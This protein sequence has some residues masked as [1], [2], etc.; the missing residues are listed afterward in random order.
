[1]KWTICQEDLPVLVRD[2]LV[3]GN[4]QANPR[5]ADKTEIETIYH[6]LI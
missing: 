4:V 6:C 3:S 2:A 5:L 1:M